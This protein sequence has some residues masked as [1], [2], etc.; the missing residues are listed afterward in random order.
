[1]PL[2]L[3]I[4]SVVLDD[5]SGRTVD[6]GIASGRIAAIERSIAADCESIDAGGSL[7]RP[8]FVETHIHLDKS[9]VIDR[10]SIVEGTLREAIAETARLKRDFSEDDIAARASRTLEKAIVA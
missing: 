3:V 5:G 2:D 4:R 10:C 1:M 7:V 9:C 6:I 8:G